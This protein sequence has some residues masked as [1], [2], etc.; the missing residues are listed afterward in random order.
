M[1]FD[2]LFIMAALESFV[3]TLEHLKF[4]SLLEWVHQLLLRKSINWVF[5]KMYL[6]LWKQKLRM[7]SDLDSQP[8]EYMMYCTLSMDGKSVNK[9]NFDFCGCYK[10]SPTVKG[11]KLSYKTKNT[12][13]EA[14]SSTLATWTS[15]EMFGL[16][17]IT[18]R[19]MMVIIVWIFAMIFGECSTDSGC[20][21]DISLSHGSDGS[22]SWVQLRIEIILIVAKI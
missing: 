6:P 7:N 9:A 17:I 11:R 18:Q 8:D 13:L 21:H 19:E 4:M 22:D 14:H 2:S 16:S 1:L 10:F 20:W 15:K 3:H 12:Q 5:N